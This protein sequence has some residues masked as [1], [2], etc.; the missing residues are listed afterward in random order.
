MSA[1][2]HRAPRH[3]LRLALVVG[4]VALLGAACAQPMPVLPP[5]P[6]LPTGYN[7]DDAPQADVAAYTQDGP[8]E[9]GVTTLELSD[10]KVEVWYPADNAQIGATP[11]DVYDVRTFL[12]DF[13]N[14]YLAGFPWVVPTF[15]TDAYRN[16]PAAAGSFPL[17]IFSHGAA[18]YRVTSTELTTHLASWGFIVISPDYLERGLLNAL[19]TPPSSPRPDTVVAAEA[20]AAAQAASATTGGLLE[21]RVDSTK[22]Y[23]WGHSAGG[24][25]SLRLLQRPDVDT[26]IPMAAG[27]SAQSLADG[28]NTP[29]LPGERITWIGGQTDG[30]ASITNVR[31]G[32]DYTQG[33]KKLVELAGGG[34]NNGFT[35]ICE[36]GGVGLIGLVYAVGLQSL[37][38][39]A[40][41]NLGGDGCSVPNW[42]DSPVLW[43]QV[44]H[45]LVAEFRYRSGLDPL[46]VG[47]GSQVIADTALPNVAV[48]NHAP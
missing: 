11:K 38:P 21:G 7:P 29:L 32:Y 12:P 39:G 37:L 33:E 19:G 45:F 3:A 23:P 43:P 13:F 2:L 6:P 4:A 30:V 46:P 48:Y 36:I 41:L 47:L 24:G 40:L 9:V 22:V 31:N 27:V 28:T 35:E 25:T 10:R 17:T 14:Q 16:V 20:I 15:E 34:H 5:K 18:G 42:E 1:H 44:G 26:A 8:Y